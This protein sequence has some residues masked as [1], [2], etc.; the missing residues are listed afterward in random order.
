MTLVINLFL[1]LNE[2]GKCILFSVN[3]NFSPL[4]P[5]DFF[6]IMICQRNINNVLFFHGQFFH[7]FL[8]PEL[9]CLKKKK[10]FLASV[11]LILKIV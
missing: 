2:K 3:F 9:C 11:Q 4:L 8:T 5:M 10:K 6:P 7:L 1:K